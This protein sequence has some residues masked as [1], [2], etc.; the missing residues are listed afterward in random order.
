MK[1]KQRPSY[2]LDKKGRLIKFNPNK[3][4]IEL[5]FI[6]VLLI[7]FCISGSFVVL[8]IYIGVLL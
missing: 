3:E 6:K 2:R 7:S 1:D 5:D 8:A 4:K